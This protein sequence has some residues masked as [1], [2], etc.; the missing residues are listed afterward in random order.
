[1]N[2]SKRKE[3]NVKKFS[4]KR[5]KNREPALYLC[6][7]LHVDKPF[8][9]CVVHHNDVW[10]HRVR[11]LLCWQESA[12]MRVKAELKH[13]EGCEAGERIHEI[14]AGAES[15]FDQNSRR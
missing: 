6:N 5:E 8:L 14:F 3:R 9:P 12:R 1:M 10:R 11:V 13:R 7:F 15:E 4:P 2:N